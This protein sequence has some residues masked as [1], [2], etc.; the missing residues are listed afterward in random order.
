MHVLHWFRVD[1]RTH[2]NTALHAA[3]KAAKAAGGPS[4]VIGLFLITPT[5]W[6]RHDDSPNKLD[7]ILRTVAELSKDLAALGIPLLIRTAAHH[8]DIP[9]LVSRVAKEVHASEVHANRQYELHELWR[10]ERTGDELRAQGTRFVLHHDQCAIP[11]GEVVV[12]APRGVTKPY[13]VYT[14]FK[15]RWIA[16]ANERGG[17]GPASSGPLVPIW[18]APYKQPA[19]ALRSDPVP[20]VL[21]VLNGPG[22]EALRASL[23]EESFAIFASS[24][25]PAARPEHAM[26]TLWPAGERAARARLETFITQQGPRYKDT[27]DTPSHS[28]VAM[29]STSRL[30]AYLAIGAI[31]PRVCIDEALRAN[32]SLFKGTLDSGSPGLVHWISE[33]LW[34][35][36]YKHLLVAFPRLCKGRAFKPETEQIRWA[37]QPEH[38]DAWQQG[39]TGIPIV[40]AGM[41]QLRATGW[42]H[43]RL[44]MITAMYLTKDLFHDWRLGERHFMRHLVDGDLSQNNGGWQ[45]SASTGTDAAPYFR[46]MNPVLQSARCDPSGTFIRHWLPELRSVPAEFIHDPHGDDVPMAIRARLDYDAPRVDRAQVKDRVMAAFQRIGSGAPEAREV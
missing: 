25:T 28:D 9:A 15:K 4:A 39:R 31:S 20:T 26:H 16:M 21:D 24:D 10:D 37:D 22:G 46:I 1:L 40:D 30:S 18:P 29:G 27:R 35:E 19:P 44:R 23:G 34:R 41:R 32:A 33:V 14:P 11:P 42:M 2:D 3:A 17:I 13:T 43:N 38:L 12:L 5:D 45:W 36:F 8:R 6:A 7:L